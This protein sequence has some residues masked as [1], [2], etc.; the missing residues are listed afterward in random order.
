[1]IEVDVS[2]NQITQ[3]LQEAEDLGNL[4][5]SITRGKSNAIGMLGE[6]IVQDYLECDRSPT[7]DYDLIHQGLKY[8]VKTKGCTCRPFHDWE[9]SIANWNTRQ[10]CDRY[11]FVRVEHIKK[12]KSNFT[13][14]AWIFGWIDK[15]E[16][17]DSAVFFKKG[18]VDPKSRIGWKFV[19]DCYNLPY[20]DLNSIK[21]IR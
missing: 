9:A 19:A 3:A 13:G 4:R 20:S 2:E 17:F 6:I 1:M 8:D 21:T 16:Y 18:Q 5:G 11:I 15:E 12:Q 7:H 10:N 14:R